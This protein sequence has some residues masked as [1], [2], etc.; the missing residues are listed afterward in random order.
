[1]AENNL[2]SA[3]QQSQ[4]TQE[5]PQDKADHSEEIVAA[6]ED[7]MSASA[8]L[9][10]SPPPFNPL[11]RTFATVPPNVNGSSVTMPI[12][13]PE[14]VATPVTVE[15]PLTLPDGA[16]LSNNGSSVVSN[17]M[18]VYESL[19][20]H[21]DGET[22][23]SNSYGKGPSPSE[24]TPLPQGHPSNNTAI[25]KSS[26]PLHIGSN[27]ESATWSY[28]TTDLPYRAPTGVNGNGIRLREGSVSE[29]SDHVTVG[30]RSLRKRSAPAPPDSKDGNESSSS[31]GGGNS[32]RSSKVRR[33]GKDT[34]GRWSKRFTWPED[35]H[36]DFVSAIFDVGLKQSS[37][38][39]ILETMPKHADVTSERIKSHLQK[40]RLHRIKSKQD[41]MT[42]YDATVRKLQKNGTGALKSLAD[43]EVA[44]HLMHATVHNHPTDLDPSQ[45]SESNDNASSK[46]QP[47]QTHPP[48]HNRKKGSLPHDALMLPQLTEKEKNSPLGT[49]MSYLMGLFFSLR[50]QL[51]AQREHAALAVA[52]RKL[53]SEPV[54]D[55]FSSFVH[56]H[57]TGSNDSGAL[58]STATAVGGSSTRSNLEQS[59]MMKREMES[60]MA[61]QNKMR[62]L[63]QQEVNKYKGDGFRMEEQH[64]EG[65]DGGELSFDKTEHPHHLATH[66]SIVS[67][68]Y[69]GAGEIDGD[70]TRGQQQH[71]RNRGLSIAN[72]EEFWNTDMVDDEL[73]K[74][75]M[76]D[77]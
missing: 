29:S 68:D 52:A 47:H 30:G 55:V 58:P 1:M 59:T 77:P 73:F 32:S 6:T 15:A 70:H 44:A 2:N 51:M 63:K 10:P 20:G 22:D 62:A 40:Y 25:H 39:T 76:S 36:R 18:R 54:A 4:Q 11:A 3:L 17:L 5:D 67:Q 26:Y 57:A 21:G 42:A 60:Q 19:T 38:S 69:Q 28:E 35:L 56:G 64:Q 45:L 13:T 33:K 75:L 9:F 65:L 61:F 27:T 71:G 7:N 14:T 53:S 66:E 16:N 23:L 24:H 72:A 43:A 12:K 37:P 48:A 8:N 46:S 34:D 41:F 49:S 74:F 50:Q 31:G